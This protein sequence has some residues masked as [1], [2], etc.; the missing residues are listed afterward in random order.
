MKR[1]LLRIGIH[2]LAIY[3]ALCLLLLFA[4]RSLIYFPTQDRLRPESTELLRLQDA[5]L[6]IS[7]RPCQGPDAL[8]YFG[9]NAEEVA[10]QLSPLAKAF[11]NHALYLMHYRGYDGS[12]GHPTEA[13]LHGDAQALYDLVRS[14]H[15]RIVVV[16]RS[17]G[18]AVA[19]RLAATRAVSRLVLVTPYDSLVSVAQQS[20]SWFPV[21]LILRDKFEAW[22]DAPRIQ[23]PT[24][25]LIAER[26]EIIPRD[27]TLALWRAFP[28]A[29]LGFEP[30]PGL[31]T[32]PSPSVRAMCRPCRRGHEGPNEGMV[33]LVAAVVAVIAIWAMLRTQSSGKQSIQV[34]KSLQF[35]KEDL[36]KQLEQMRTKTALEYRIPVTDRRTMADWVGLEF[37]SRKVGNT[38]RVA[39]SPGAPFHVNGKPGEP[40]VASTSTPLGWMG[41][42]GARSC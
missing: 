18:T 40:L 10:Y 21:R 7:V 39:K 42:R 11:P 1:I 15:S 17:L 28:P 26:D 27:S 41:R 24:Q 5:S 33:L 36:T 31:R 37:F 32:I 19:V 6:Q 13:H 2:A 30:S 14:R 20:Y 38:G 34:V 3:T 35:A 16:G 4:Q 23:A 25:I 9:G 29:S 12:T 22:R 8:I